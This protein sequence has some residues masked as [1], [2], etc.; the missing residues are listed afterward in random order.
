MSAK[1]LTCENAACSAGTLKLLYQLEVQ[2]RASDG[3][4]DLGV[5]WGGVEGLLEAGKGFLDQTLARQGLALFQVFVVVHRPTLNQMG[6]PMSV[7]N[8]PAES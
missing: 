7:Y 5:L 1:G 3:L 4:Y 2:K 6:R 8:P